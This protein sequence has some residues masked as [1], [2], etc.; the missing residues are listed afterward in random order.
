M[1]C[2]NRLAINKMVLQYPHLT[3]LST[4]DSNLPT[5]RPIR[6]LLLSILMIVMTTPGIAGELTID[7]SSGKQLLDPSLDYLLDENRQYRL[8]DIIA[9]P[10]NPPLD[11]KSGRQR[12]DIL[13]MKPGVYWF[14]GDIFNPL[15]QPQTVAL[16]TE[17][18]TIHS[19][20]L[21]SIDSS[22]NLTTHYDRSGFNQAFSD[23]PI[24]H[25]NLVA[26]ITVAANST[27]TLIWRVEFKPLVQFR[28]T[29]WQPD[30]FFETD[31]IQQMVYGMLYGILVVMA[32]YNLF[33]YFST[34]Q[35]S[36]IYYVLYMVS[37]LYIMASDLGHTHQYILPTKQW[38]KLT[39]YTLVYAFN[40][41]LFSQFCIYFLDLKK[42]SLPLMN[43][44]R[45]VAISCF[46]SVL[47]LA[48]YSN[49]PLVFISLTTA[50][51]LY[52]LALIAGI[53]VRK[54]GVTSAGHFIIAI[55][56]LVFSMAAN[57]MARLGLIKNNSFT[58]NLNA[59][60]TV[61]MLVFFSLA[62]AD[63]IN[64]LHKE[65]KENKKHIA[66]ANEE[67]RKSHT[68]LLKAQSDRIKLEQTASQAKRESR[69][70]SGFLATMSHEINSP[71]L[72]ISNMT[73]LMKSTSLDEKQTQYLN[74]IEH[75][76]QSLTAIINDLQD[77]AK[78]E[79]GEMSLEIASFNLE[80]LVDDCISTFS[81]RA[82]EKDLEF[83]ADIEPGIP[84]VL[85][86]DANKL[87][88]IILNLLSNAFKFTEQ[89]DILL[90]VASTG[91]P[92]VNSVELKI[93][94]KDSG[95]GLTPEEQQRL[96]TPFQHAGENTYG[97]FGG[98][99]LGLSIS[100][101]LADLMD[102]II[103]VESEAGKG[104]EFW[105]TARLIID[106]KPDPT[107]LR[108][109]SSLL[110]GKK[111]LLLDANP[112]STD[113][114]ARLLQ[115]WHMDVEHCD[116]V[117]DAMELL[118]SHRQ[119]PFDIVLAEYNLKNSD[120]LAVA[121]F[122][123]EQQLIDTALILM[124]ASRSLSNQTSLNDN[125][126]KIVLEKP[127]TNTLLHDALIQALSSSND[128]S[129]SAELLT[130]DPS[131]LNVLVVEDNKVNQLVLMGLL[132]QL[133]ITP[134]LATNGLE[135]LNHYEHNDFD[136]ILMDCEMPEMDGY[137]ASH[138]IRSKEK[139]S[140]RKRVTI[141]A[142]SSHARSDYL[143]RSQQAGMDQCLTKPVAPRELIDLINRIVI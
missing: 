72:E 8:E 111:L 12:E 49:F 32:L 115:H 26:E 5:M 67:K 28:A 53:I 52:I 27:S 24:S 34:K 107:L 7:V 38:D 19:A 102:G 23:R 18:P 108:E 86:G 25:R 14:K 94:V 76:G 128:I 85:Q 2:I 137:E 131:R 106:E 44:I 71:M 100:K 42:Y 16:L 116:N 69:S 10:N 81:L 123:K 74:A 90:T 89:G 63:L 73:E 61:M 17:Y 78:I 46:A 103:G 15:T 56:I 58:E 99:G 88:Q 142:L 54:A 124:V 140:G 110:N 66:T 101:Q 30:D 21:Y 11:W 138:Q 114:I 126:I 64:Q 96:F 125:S 135:A 141:A 93:T 77:F 104:S 109:K 33:L 117:Q 31:Q 29:L 48:I 47:L 1:S 87:K 113:I 136:L 60:G 75:S 143:T 6:L 41:F 91:K 98:S 43:L 68:E 22:N 79:A 40:V 51:L 119:Q 139:H 80:T 20:T 129:R 35:K 133:G 3:A 82:V 112:V 57:N 118:A 45:A 13:L 55:L 95:I 130:I 83:I 65:N 121:S 37:A 134:E 59:L 92:S 36:Y 4:C 39:V 50:T 97:E 62:L 105:F 127:I 9:T 122:I 70:K 132:K 120:S 84:P